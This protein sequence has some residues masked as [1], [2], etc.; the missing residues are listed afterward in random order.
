[1]LRKHVRHESNEPEQGLMAELCE[2]EKE[3]WNPLT[4]NLMT[5]H[6]SLCKEDFAGCSSRLVVVVMVAVMVVTLIVVDTW[7]CEY[8]ISKCGALF[9]SVFISVNLQWLLVCA[10]KTFATQ[11]QK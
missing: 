6:I 2:H 9:L 11:S 7:T 1:M 5:S 10:H 4:Q 3:T 8:Y